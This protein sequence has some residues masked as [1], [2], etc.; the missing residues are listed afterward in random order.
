MPKKKGANKKKETSAREHF[1][2]L[3]LTHEHVQN[4][5]VCVYI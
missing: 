5:Y 1:A 3:Q 2:P 4:P